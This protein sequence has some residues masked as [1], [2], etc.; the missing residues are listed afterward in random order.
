MADNVRS[1]P[2][3]ELLWTEWRMLMTI[4]GA[5]I[6]LGVLMIAPAPLTTF[7]AVVV[8]GCFILAGDLTPRRDLH[9]Q[10]V[11]QAQ[12]CAGRSALSLCR[13]AHHRESRGGR[14]IFDRARGSA[15]PGRRHHADRSWWLRVIEL[16]TGPGL[17]SAFENRKSLTMTPGA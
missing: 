3:L 8:V 15:P 5:A 17:R 11:D 16:R 7:A 12:A 14:N 2:E 6:I 1:D 13:H 10:R 4:G 9:R